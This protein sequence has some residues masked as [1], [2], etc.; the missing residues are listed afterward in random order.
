MGRFKYVE[1]YS[2]LDTDG[3][4]LQNQGISSQRVMNIPHWWR[5][6]METFSALLAV[7]AGNSPVPGEFPAPRPVTRSFNVFFDLRLNKRLSKQWWGWWFETLSR[8]L[9]RHRNEVSPSTRFDVLCVLHRH[10]LATH[11][12][13]DVI[14]ST[15]A[16]QVTS[17]TIVYSTVYPDQRKH[18]SSASLAFVRGTHRWPVNSPHKAPVTRKMFPF[19]DVILFMSIM[20]SR[21]SLYHPVYPAI[22]QVTWLTILMLNLFVQLYD[23]DMFIIYSHK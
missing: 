21:M 8:P 23:I 9:W 16:S 20:I 11:H 6:Q 22:S 10:Y 17:L 2:A 1:I 3:Q 12:Y 19:D 5:H 15:I 18:Q 7:C 14:K 4:V 13:S